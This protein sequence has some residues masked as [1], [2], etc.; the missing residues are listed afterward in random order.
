MYTT[1][2]IKHILDVISNSSKYISNT[3]PNY[4]T[5]FASINP[6]TENDSEVQINQDHEIKTSLQSSSQKPAVHQHSRSLTFMGGNV[7]KLVMY[8]SFKIN[9]DKS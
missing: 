9:P 1:I 7:N 4:R 2:R 5:E 8:K 3:Y 6:D